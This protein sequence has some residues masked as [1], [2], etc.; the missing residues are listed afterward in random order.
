MKRLY[1]INKH[2]RYILFFI[3]L[4][5]GVAVLVYIISCFTNKDYFE[6][7][8][9]LTVII[10]GVWIFAHQ[11][12]VNFLFPPLLQINT[13]FSDTY[14]KLPYPEKE[15]YFTE[16]QYV[17]INVKNTGLTTAKDISIKIKGV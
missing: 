10:F 15:K 7:I 12:T 13:W 5:F 16:V 2:F 9:F 11:Q 6:L 8:S 17:N 4:F 3:I 1:L 14:M